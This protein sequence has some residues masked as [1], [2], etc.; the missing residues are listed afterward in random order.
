[1]NHEPGAGE[2]VRYRWP[3]RIN[4]WIVA[5]SFVLVALSGMS[6]FHP[7]LFPLATLF[8]GGPWTRILHPFLGLVMAAAFAL[9]AWRMWR[10]NLL[11]RNDIRWLLDIREVLENKDN[12]L[13]PVGR[14]NGGQ[15]LLFWVIVGCLSAL[16][17]TGL[18]IWRAY[19]SQYFAIGLVRFSVLVHAFCGS[20]QSRTRDRESAKTA[21]VTPPLPDT[22]YRAR[23]T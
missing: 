6:L 15:K 5:I 23:Q 10:D 13:P 20:R 4:H 12:S 21:A 8:G 2:I 3:T 16:L 14:F 22:L 11:T 1:M 19:F 18:V 17:L 9:L 7:A